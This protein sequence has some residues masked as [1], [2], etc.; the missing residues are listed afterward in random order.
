LKKLIAISFLIVFLS[1]NTELHQLL[2]LPVL[3]HH[4]FD[5][6]N[7][8]PSETI[9]DFLSE[10]YSASKNQSTADKHDRKHNHDNL[11]FKSNDCATAHAS[12]TFEIQTPF[13][14]PRPIILREKNS[15]IYNKTNY[16]S[17]IV[18][19]IWQPPKIS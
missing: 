19:N 2:K 11:P 1:A 16:S 5:H 3:I 9:V 12:L 14:I 17:A 8:Q 6:H 15:P 13:S 10:H 18:S 7:Q 4:F